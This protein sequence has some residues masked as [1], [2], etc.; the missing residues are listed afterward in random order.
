MSDWVRLLRELF[1]SPAKDD[2]PQPCMTTAEAQALL[3]KIAGKDRAASPRLEQLRSRAEDARS[4]EV[5]TG[6]LFEQARAL[7]IEVERDLFAATMHHENETNVLRAQLRRRA[8][9]LLAEYG[10]KLFRLQDAARLA[11]QF[12]TPPPMRDLAT[13]RLVERLDTSNAASVQRVLEA[14]GDA[15]KEIEKLSEAAI[16]D[17]DLKVRLDELIAAIPDHIEP[18]ESGVKL[19]TEGERRELQLRL[20]GRT[21]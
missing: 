12:R 19:L 20:Q 10:S 15:F 16:S 9:P 13:G 17:E 14:V 21:S 7:R 5:A 4:R 8:S 18:P 2:V 6:A 1:Q 11:V 3:D